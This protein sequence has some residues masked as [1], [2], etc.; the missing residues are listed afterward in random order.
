[1]G[2]LAVEAALPERSGATSLGRNG[3]TAR[4][5]G[6]LGRVVGRRG[7]HTRIVKRVRQGS[8]QAA[9]AMRKRVGTDVKNMLHH[10][11]LKHVTL[12]TLLGTTALIGTAGHAF[13][14]DVP[15]ALAGPAASA[16]VIRAPA[17]GPQTIV[18]ENGGG[19]S[20]VVL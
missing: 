5:T 6:R 4:Q 17:P 14:Q 18:L 7:Q 1:R 13:A 16:A 11:Q 19:V 9:P 15:A 8:G 10:S 12:A 3:R 20:V 2:A